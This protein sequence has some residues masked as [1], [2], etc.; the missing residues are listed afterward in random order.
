MEHPTLFV[1]LWNTS[2]I[3]LANVRDPSPRRNRAFSKTLTAASPPTRPLHSSASCS[4]QPEQ[5]GIF[6]GQFNANSSWPTK[7]LI[8]CRRRCHYAFHP[9]TCELLTWLNS[10]AAFLR[11]FEGRFRRRQKR[12]RLRRDGLS[13]IAIAVAI[14]TASSSPGEKVVFLPFVADGSSVVADHLWSE[15]GLTN[16]T[17]KPDSRSE[18]SD[19]TCIPID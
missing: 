17:G 14:Q 4:R 7:S 3:M 16:E 9:R 11:A 1:T 19:R 2:N 8:S 6:F 18:I 5:G 12:K 15:I 13:A 10:P